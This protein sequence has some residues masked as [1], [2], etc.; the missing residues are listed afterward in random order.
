MKLVCFSLLVLLWQRRRRRRSTRFAKC[1][2]T[3]LTDSKYCII[4][5]R[6]RRES[7]RQ[8]QQRR[9]TYRIHILCVSAW[10]RTINKPLCD[11]EYTPSTYTRMWCHTH[12]QYV[13]SNRHMYFHM[14]IHIPILYRIH[15][16]IGIRNVDGYRVLSMQRDVDV[17]MCLRARVFCMPL[18]RYLTSIQTIEWE[19]ECERVCQRARQRQAKPM[20]VVT[21]ERRQQHKCWLFPYFLCD[22]GNNHYRI[23][24]RRG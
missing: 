8:W 12:T 21:V 15:T 4:W 7:E 19:S 23:P 11:S 22:T 13:T 2:A 9:K 24:T 20:R 5:L 14:E 6:G 17:S 1:S 3:R 10:A 16:A 18:C